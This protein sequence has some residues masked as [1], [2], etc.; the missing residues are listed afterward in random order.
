MVENKDCEGIPNLFNVGKVYFGKLLAFLLWCYLVVIDYQFL[1]TVI[2][3][4]QQQMVVFLMCTVIRW[5][6]QCAI[7]PSLSAS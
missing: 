2:H 4:I 6:S 3:S 1:R 7:L 5:K